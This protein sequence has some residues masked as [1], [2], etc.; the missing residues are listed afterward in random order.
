VRFKWNLWKA[1]TNT[2][3]HGVAFPEAATVFGGPPAITFQ[4][5]N[6]SEAVERYA[7][8]ILSLPNRLATAH[9]GMLRSNKGRKH[10]PNG[11]QRKDGVRKRLRR[12]EIEQVSITGYEPQGKPWTLIR[13]KPRGMDPARF[14]P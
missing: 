6:Q 13:G 1:A 2:T 9:T 3:K 12:V 5:P 10:A 8:S 11:R 14:K 7:T 4:D